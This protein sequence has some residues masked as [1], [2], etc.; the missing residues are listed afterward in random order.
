MNTSEY[1]V[2]GRRF[3][4]GP[5]KVIL[6]PE[7]IALL[8]KY[9]KG[10]CLDVGFGSGAYS[11]FLHHAG[12]LTTGVD[13]QKYFVKKALKKYPE[14]DFQ[15]GKAEKLPFK[16]NQFDTIVAFDIL[17]HIDDELAIKEIFRVGKRLIFSVPLRNQKVLTSHGLAHAHY[18]DK[19]HLRTYTISSAKKLFNRKKHKTIILEKS[20]PLSISGFLIE[21]L[22]AGNRTLRLLLKIILKPFLPEPPIYSTIFGVID[23]RKKQ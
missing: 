17:E 3:G 13:S 7:K 5:D 12:H 10:T 8:Q 2:N 23:T 18:L 9:A 11:N 14:I 20:L 1:I 4:W 21:R 6:N 15:S 16:N 22:S 19:T